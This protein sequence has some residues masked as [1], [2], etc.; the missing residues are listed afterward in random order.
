MAGPAATEVVSLDE[1]G[2]T[3]PLARADDM[4]A[5]LSREDVAQDLVAG[6]RALFAL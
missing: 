5:F 4:N 2:K 3:A 6:L 1:S